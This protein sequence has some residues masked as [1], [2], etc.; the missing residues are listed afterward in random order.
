MSCNF[1]TAQFLLRSH[2]AELLI[3]DR[4][5]CMHLAFFMKFSAHLLSKNMTFSSSTDITFLT[6]FLV[7]GVTFSYSTKFFVLK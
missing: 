5:P 7:L 2:Q 6:S 3:A 4:W 1:N